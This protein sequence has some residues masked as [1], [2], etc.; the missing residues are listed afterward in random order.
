[1]PAW[2]GI[3]VGL[4]WSW[5]LQLNVSS[6]DRI[7]ERAFVRNDILEFTSRQTPPP[8]PVRVPSIVRDERCCR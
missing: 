7:A 2:T 8:I 6:T 1:M 4:T 5:T 3:E